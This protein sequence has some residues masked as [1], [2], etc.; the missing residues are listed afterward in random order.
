MKNIVSYDIDLRKWG[1]GYISACNGISTVHGEG[2]FLHLGISIGNESCDI[3]KY[4]V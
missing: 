2:V 4:V 3:R 1:N